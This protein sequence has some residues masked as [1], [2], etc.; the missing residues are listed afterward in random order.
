MLA[1]AAHAYQQTQVMT[2]NQVQL[3][4]LLY[5]SAIQSLELAREAILTNN[6]KDKARFLDRSMAI[7]G[8]LDSVLD[9]EHGGEIARSLHRLYDYMVQQ[10]I[11]ANL[12]HKGTHLDGPIRC[13]TTLREAWQVVARQETV[14]HAGK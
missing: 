12:R 7:V 6:Y 2:A 10:C 1:H 5:D 13:L 8:E 9:F 3:I 14:A 11:Q 4:V